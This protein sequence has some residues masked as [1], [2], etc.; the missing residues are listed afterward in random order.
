MGSFEYELGGRCSPVMIRISTGHSSI[1]KPR[2][3]GALA[4]RVV[5]MMGL[6]FRD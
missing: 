2:F 3:V 4:R 5:A 6:N 1:S